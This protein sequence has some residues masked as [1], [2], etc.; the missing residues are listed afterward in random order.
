[1]LSMPLSKSEQRSCE[2]LWA[3]AETRT[4]TNA[5]TIYEE[6]I[7]AGGLWWWRSLCG[8]PVKQISIMNAFEWLLVLAGQQ[9]TVPEQLHSAL[10]HV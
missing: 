2:T 8:M 5:L 9:N 1:M 4:T 10:R 6:R 3:N 7:G